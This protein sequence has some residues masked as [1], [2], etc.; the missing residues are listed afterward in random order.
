MSKKRRPKIA[1]YAIAK[2]EAK[3]VARFCEAAS[4]ADII[5]IA[6]TGSTDDTVALARKAGAVVHNISVS[7]WRFDVARNAALALV[8]AD[9]DIC[10]SMDLDEILQPGWRKVV[11]KAWTDGVT[12]IAYQFDHG[13]DSTL[14]QNKIHS[15]NGYVWRWVC[16]EWPMP[17]RI[18]E[19]VATVN[20]TMAIH[21]PDLSK[22]RAQYLDLM[23]AC[24]VEEPNSARHC[25]LYAGELYSHSH[26]EKAI[27][28]FTRLINLQETTDPNEK[29]YAYRMMSRAAH[30]M[31]DSQAALSYARQC[32]AESPNLRESWCTL[33]WECAQ[34]ELWLE[35]L[36]AAS[37]AISVKDRGDF[38]L[39]ED[40]VWK[41]LPHELAAS[42]LKEMGMHELAKQ[43]AE[44]AL[45][46]GVSHDTSKEKM[47]LILSEAS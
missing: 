42:A 8:P 31:G 28:E 15:R 33:A 21:K 6:D 32:V 34:Q 46:L 4:A 1:V 7:P 14:T 27:S 44:M 12:R 26:Y 2:N 9:V 18:N 29:G 24:A 36:S 45:L 19:V 43:H 13:N 47:Q 37:A 20:F 35:C 22:S 39:T 17:D 23:Y 3:H 30:H 25:K 38:Y 5:V 41:G 40:N 10:V 11:E 16:H